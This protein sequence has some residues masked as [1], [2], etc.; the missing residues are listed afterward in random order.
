MLFLAL[1]MHNQLGAGV[2]QYEPG[3]TIILLLS[4]ADAADTWEE[5][6]GDLYMYVH[7]QNELHGGS[8]GL[9]SGGSQNSI[10][11]DRTTVDSTAG[12]VQK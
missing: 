1:Q 8:G 5:G 11:Q 12:D 2:F 4:V 7:G 6:G 10:F 3:W 9:C